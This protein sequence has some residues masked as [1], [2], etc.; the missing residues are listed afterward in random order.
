MYGAKTLST[1]MRSRPQTD[2]VWM[3]AASSRANLERL[4]RKRDG[5]SEPTDEAQ[6]AQVMQWLVH[7]YKQGGADAVRQMLQGIVPNVANNQLIEMLE[8]I[9]NGDEAD[10]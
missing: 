3:N 4:K 2:F 1:L 10:E 5:V 9:A 6:S 8:T 7:T